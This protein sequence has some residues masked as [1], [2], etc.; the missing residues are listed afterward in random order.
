[1]C[2]AKSN[3]S[4]ITL[5]NVT[6]TYSLSADQQ[7]QALHP[8]S[9][10]IAPAEFVAIMGPSGSGK[11]TL[12]NIIGC[13]DYP[14]SGD[15]LFREQPIT[16]LSNRELAALRNQ[17]F[18]FVFQS[19]NLLSRRTVLDNV[20]MPLVYSGLNRKQRRH[21][22]Q[23]ALQQVELSDYAAHYPNQLSGGQQ[24]RVA[25]ARA[26][27]N[28]PKI[29]LADEPT[30][31]LDTH[32]GAEIMQIFVHLNQKENI[33]IVLVTHETEIAEYASRQIRMRDGD[34]EYDSAVT[35]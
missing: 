3:D 29:L 17:W 31:N 5:D 26:L 1:M 25:I 15:Y 23:K 22:A 19:F 28:Q 20:A 27:I 30:G 18:G 10:S 2:V 21:R 6:K 7:F 32:L 34:I 14:S 8:V 4:L 11:S 35:S 12:M 16:A 33:T 13:L 9:I 24:Q